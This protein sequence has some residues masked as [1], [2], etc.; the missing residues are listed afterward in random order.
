M[1]FRTYYLFYV[2]AGL[3]LILGLLTIKQSVVAE[4]EYMDGLNAYWPYFIGNSISAFLVAFIYHRWS[5]AGRYVNKGVIILHFVL[6]V[7]GLFFSISSYTVVVFFMT[8]TGPDTSAISI[9]GNTWLL[10]ALGPVLLLLS[11]AVFVFGL[12][13]STGIKTQVD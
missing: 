1:N 13:N 2:M 8:L 6:A 11:L 9:G 7:L 4:S 12:I 3:L 5:R 10:L